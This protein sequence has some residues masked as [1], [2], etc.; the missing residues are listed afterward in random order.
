MGVRKG[1]DGK[2][3]RLFDMFI[4]WGCAFAICL[5]LNDLYP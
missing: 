1:M 3:C 2:R 4:V 5:K